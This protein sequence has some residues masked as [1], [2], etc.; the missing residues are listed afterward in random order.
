MKIFGVAAALLLCLALHEWAPDIAID[1]ASGRLPTTALATFAGA[2][3]VLWATAYGRLSSFEKLDDLR[4]TQRDLVLRKT[5]SFKRLIIRSIALNALLAAATL[6]ANEFV[7]LPSGAQHAGPWLA[8]LIFAA[9]GFWLGG[10]AQSKVL[11][12]SI[13]TSRDAMHHAQAAER[14]RAKYLQQIRSDAKSKPVDHHDKHLA[15]YST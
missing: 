10:L 5:S 2:L 4:Q 11:L 13:E 12:T 9:C 3:T 15:G 8:Y 6:G 7:K 14:A 1:V